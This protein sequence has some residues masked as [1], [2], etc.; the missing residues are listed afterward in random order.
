MYTVTLYFSVCSN[1]LLE[2]LEIII[3][4]FFPVTYNVVFKQPIQTWIIFTWYG[5]SIMMITAYIFGGGLFGIFI[6]NRY[7]VNKWRDMFHLEYP[8]I[9]NLAKSYLSE[10]KC[11]LVTKY[12]KTKPQLG[13]PPVITVFVGT[14]DGGQSV[15]VHKFSAIGRDFNHNGL[16]SSIV[17]DTNSYYSPPHLS[18]AIGFVESKGHIILDFDSADQSSME[19]HYQD[20]FLSM[21]KND[22]IPI[23]TLEI[24][25]D[26]YKPHHGGMYHA[27]VV[28]GYLFGMFSYTPSWI[29][30]G[31][32]LALHG[33]MDSTKLKIIPFV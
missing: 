3:A 23:Y 26:I 21:A 1:M 18:Q 16:I 4:L 22:G 20:I 10:E 6:N 33:P 12:T 5:L 15:L 30:M 32:K 14:R 29:A 31:L 24:E 11:I 19:R 8:R 28:I 7:I 2:A 27:S 17:A 13:D 25:T 9:D